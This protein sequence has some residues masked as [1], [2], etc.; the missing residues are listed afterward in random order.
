MSKAKKGLK[1]LQDIVIE[2]MLGGKN[3]VQGPLLLK[4]LFVGKTY[5]TL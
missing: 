1:L 3:S 2:T 4:V 5:W